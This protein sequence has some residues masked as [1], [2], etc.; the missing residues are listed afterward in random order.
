MLNT[1]R[2]QHNLV[3]ML[4]QSEKDLL[5]RQFEDGLSIEELADAYGLTVPT[6]GR[7]L[8]R[9]GLIER[10]DV[11]SYTD[12]AMLALVKSLGIH[13]AER[14]KEVISGSQPPVPH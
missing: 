12:E 8:A 4:A 7:V 13:T 9:I 10:S 11:L 14:L 5:T 3:E 2:N 6:M 1:K